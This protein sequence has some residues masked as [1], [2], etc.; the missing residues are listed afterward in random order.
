MALSSK[1]KQD[2][3]LVID[4]L[5]LNQIKTRK[6]VEI[7]NTLEKRDSLVVING[8]NE[9]LELSA[10][11]IP[12]VKVLRSEGLNVYDILKYKNLILLKSTIEDI[13]RRLLQ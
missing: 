5:E 10:K 1:F 7:I 11:N 13:E 9:I 12:D 4:R 6:F 8:K 2:R 3:L